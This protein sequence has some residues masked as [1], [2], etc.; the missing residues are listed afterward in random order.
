MRATLIGRLH[1][2]VSTGQNQQ[3]LQAYEAWS[4]AA[5]PNRG[6]L[7]RKRVADR[8]PIAK[9]LGTRLFTTDIAFFVFAVESY[10][11]WRS[12]LL[13]HTAAAELCG[14]NVTDALDAELVLSGELAQAAGLSSWRAFANPS[15]IL[16]CLDDIGQEVVSQEVND[17]KAAISELFDG[18]QLIDLLGTDHQNLIPKQLRHATGAHYTPQW[19]AR[20]TLRAAGYSS[21]NRPIRTTRI[22]DPTCGSGIFLIAAA[23]DIQQ[24]VTQGRMDVRTALALLTTDIVGMDLDPLAATQAAANLSIA[25]MRTAFQGGVDSVPGS[26]RVYCEDSLSP[27]IDIGTVDLVVGNPPWVNWEYLPLEYREKHADLWPRLGMFDLKGKDKAFSK[28]DVSALFLTH[29]IQR[30]LGTNG[31]LAFLVPQSLLKA[32]LNHRGFRKFGADDGSLKYDGSARFAIRHVDDFVAVRP[33]EGV[34]NRTILIVAEKDESTE[35][36]VPYKRWTYISPS[37]RAQ[38][39]RGLYLREC[40]STKS[41]SPQIPSTS[42]ATGR[43]GHRTS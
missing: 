32:A 36:P 41:A 22:M 35:Y 37:T 42:P 14:L 15:W 19:L 31:T 16:E 3:A 4:S 39:W 43:P 29:S 13:I 18:G 33:F 2:V 30:Y 12:Y 24:E 7:E 9:L 11:A 10:L 28:E 17:A 20:Y 23:E 25:A 6:H 8:D 27:Q 5:L 38:G 40:M 21:I 34:S 1:E 26:P